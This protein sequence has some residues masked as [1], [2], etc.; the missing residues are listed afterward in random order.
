MNPA[1][2]A[3]FVTANVP[4]CQ[5]TRVFLHSDFDSDNVLVHLHIRKPGWD[6]MLTVLVWL[7]PEL[8]DEP[9]AAVATINRMVGAEADERWYERQCRRWHGAQFA[10]LAQLERMMQ[11]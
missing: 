5:T 10:H 1:D 8:L 6:Y 3:D 2:F 4:D 11:I 7:S 9:N